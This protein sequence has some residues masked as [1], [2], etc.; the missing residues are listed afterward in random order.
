M[1]RILLFLSLILLFNSARSQSEYT[2]EAPEGSFWKTNYTFLERK[3]R[4]SYEISYPV[5]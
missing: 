2:T 1:Q 3:I 4:K 5:F